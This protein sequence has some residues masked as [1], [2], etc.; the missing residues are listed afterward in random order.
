[1]WSV[2]NCTI[3]R[4]MA[5]LGDKWTFIV[6]REV[7]TG[8]RRFEQ[9]RVRTNIPRQVLTNRLDK[10]VAEGVLRREPYREEGARARYEY[11][12]TDKGFALYPVLT[13][14]LTWGTTYLSD[15][16][17][18]PIA[19]VHRDCGAQV[20]APLRCTAGHDIDSARDVLPQPGPGARRR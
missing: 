10:L 16:E 9:M 15:P 18:P 3:T 1:M 2:D 17:G 11:R 4:A 12:L 20:D 13:A 6:L 14:L 19:F 8:V 7:F 5:T